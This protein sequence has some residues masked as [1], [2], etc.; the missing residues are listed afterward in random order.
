MSTTERVSRRSFFRRL[1]ATAGGLIAGTAVAV[2]LV[3][4]R[5]SE[6]KWIAAAGDV[7]A[8]R[9]SDRVEDTSE[10]ILND[11]L[12]QH[13][14]V[15]G[16]VQYSGS[17]DL[18]DATWGRFKD[19][20]FPCPGNHDY[21]SSGPIDL[22]DDYWGSLAPKQNGRNYVV[23]LE[24]G[25]TLFSLDSDP[26]YEPLLTWLEEQLATLPP[27]QKIIA[28]WHHPIYDEDG[29]EVDTPNVVPMF[30]KLFEHR[31]DLLL[32]GH[33]HNYARFPRMG[34]SGLPDA[35]G[36]YCIL[37]GTGGMFLN[38]ELATGG[39]VEASSVEWGVLKLFLDPNGFKG[40][41][42][43]YTGA[44]IDTFDNGNGGL[45]ECLR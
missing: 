3:G 37:V 38:T 17:Y 25:W 36:P 39:N 15:M 32:Y 20:T 9:N 23:D 34:N 8:N 43:D 27:T 2:A 35:D 1:I 29:T 41:F 19:K 40:Q 45:I 11:P 42:V 24:C 5:R 10:L 14:L 21:G 7:A 6:G 16:D 28:F 22:Y 12:I 44:T 18:Y 30:D 13:V 33:K 26:G 31:C 4:R